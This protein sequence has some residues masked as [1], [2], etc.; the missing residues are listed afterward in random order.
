M[1]GA[2][3]VGESSSAEASRK[4]SSLR[5]LPAGIEHKHRFTEQDNQKAREFLTKAIE[6]DPSFARYLYR[7]GHDACCRDRQRLDEFAGYH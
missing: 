3:P 4:S 2:L 5:E 7:L 1:S 6:I